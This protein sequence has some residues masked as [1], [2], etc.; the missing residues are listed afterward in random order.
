MVRLYKLLFFALFGY[1]VS[2]HGMHNERTPG[3]LPTI[4]AW[5]VVK[6]DI[7]SGAFM[8]MTNLES[9]LLLSMLTALKLWCHG[10]F[11]FTELREGIHGAVAIGTLPLFALTFSSLLVTG[12]YN[13]LLYKRTDFHAS[14]K[15]FTIREIVRWFC[16]SF[17]TVISI[18]FL[19]G[20][21]QEYPNVL[22]NTPALVVWNE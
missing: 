19:R 22:K 8:F 1:S 17:S 14:Q 4:T 3:A 13:I 16:A 9:T 21:L 11:N 7:F 6:N 2:L 5:E 12:S 18:R 10:G 20:F 15:V